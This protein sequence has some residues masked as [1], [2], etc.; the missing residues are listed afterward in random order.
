MSEELQ[1]EK[2]CGAVVYCQ[3]GNDIKYLLVC[4]HGGYWVFPKGHM[5]T[6]E[7][8][9]E[10]AL[11]EVKEETGL[12]VAFVDGFRVKDEHNLAR[13]GR[14]NTIKQTIYFLAN[15]ENQTFVPQESEISRIVLLDFEAAMATLQFDSFK[16][17]L[18][19][20]HNFLEQK[21]Y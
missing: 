2:S 1:Y 3:K 7:S 19:R 6:G 16:H 5:E 20:A 13:E 17:I 11:R 9:H 8:E 15:Y 14:P 21:R 18:T 12:D 10:T 4:E